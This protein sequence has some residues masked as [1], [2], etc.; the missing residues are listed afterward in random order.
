[1]NRSVLERTCARAFTWECP[2]WRHSLCECVIP[3]LSRFN[4]YAGNENS[5]KYFTKLFTNYFFQNIQLFFEFQINGFLP[6]DRSI[7]LFPWSITFMFIVTIILQLRQSIVEYR[8]PS[9]ASNC[10][11]LGPL[12]SNYSIFFVVGPAGL[13]LLRLSAPRPHCKR[14][15][16]H[17][18][19]LILAVNIIKH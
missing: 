9:I 3:V 10:I 8:P 11:Y 12:P 15:L 6:T 16:V 7:F 17:L 4:R 14:V 5:R 18:L 19:S 2:W 13:C 1:M